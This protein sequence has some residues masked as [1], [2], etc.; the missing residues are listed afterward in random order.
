VTKT[1]PPTIK[2]EILFEHREI[3]FFPRD[4][5]EPLKFRIG[6]LYGYFPN[7]KEGRY[8]RLGDYSLAFAEFKKPDGTRGWIDVWGNEYQRK[9]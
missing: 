7:D 2:T 6:N 5:N 1:T 4:Y 3:D 8:R 9:D